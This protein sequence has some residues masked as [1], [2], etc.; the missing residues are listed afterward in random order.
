MYGKK[1]AFA[2][3]SSGEEMFF[4]IMDKENLDPKKIT[5]VRMQAQDMPTAIATKQIDA[6]L[7]WEPYPSLVVDRK[8]ARSWSGGRNTSGDTP[9]SSFTGIS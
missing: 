1:V 2:T 8:R 5:I 4:S 9:I 6:F 7:A 3:A